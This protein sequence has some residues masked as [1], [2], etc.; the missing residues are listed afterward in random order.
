MKIHNIDFNT[1]KPKEKE[2]LVFGANTEGRHSLGTALIARK[3]WGAIYGTPAG[4]QGKAFAIIT[5]DL[6]KK[7]HPSIDEDFIKSQIKVLYQ[8]AETQPDTIF[9]IPYK[10]EGKNLNSYSSEELANM[11]SSFRIPKNISFEE[12]FSKLL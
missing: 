5:K 1:Y 3:S 9:Y 6:T 11:F 7:V 10:G 12:S 2:I 8:Y 4:L